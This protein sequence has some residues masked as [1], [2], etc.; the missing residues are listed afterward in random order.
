MGFPLAFDRDMTGIWPG[1]HR[2]II[3]LSL[4]LPFA[5]VRLS[6]GEACSG[7]MFTVYRFAPG[8]MFDVRRSG[9]SKVQEV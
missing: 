1:Y 8:L 9:S 4:W 3:M 2:D 7:D 6:L 5:V